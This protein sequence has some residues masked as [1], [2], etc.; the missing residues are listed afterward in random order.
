MANSKGKISFQSQ[1]DWDM[2]FEA[3]KSGY[4]LTN[5]DIDVPMAPQTYPVV[6]VF[7]IAETTMQVSYIYETDL[8]G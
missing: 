3:M 7:E 6:V 1:S 4:S 8:I 5:T 2:W